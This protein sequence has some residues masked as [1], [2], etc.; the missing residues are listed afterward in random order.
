MSAGSSVGQTAGIAADRR[1]QGSKG[2][3]T[4]PLARPQAPTSWT[5]VDNA[6][7]PIP[8]VERFLVYLVALGRSPRTV[9]AYATTLHLFFQ[10]LELREFDVF[11][12]TLDELANFFTWLR[13]RN[14]PPQGAEPASARSALSDRTLNLRKRLLSTFYRF[15]AVRNP[16]SETLGVLSGLGR[17]WS[18]QIPTSEP[19][20]H[21]VYIHDEVRRPRPKTITDEQVRE[22]LDACPTARDRF[23]LHLL[24]QSGLRIGEAL[25]LHHEDLSP[26]RQLVRVVPRLDNTNGARVK[27]MRPRQVPVPDSVFDSYAHYMT[28]DYREIDS[29]YVFVHLRKHRG[30]PQTVGSVDGVLRKVR[31]QT[32]IRFTPQVARHSYA[33]RL[34]RAGVPLDT[35]ADLLGHADARQTRRTYIHLEVEDHRR[36]LVAAGVLATAQ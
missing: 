9:L 15:Y 25:G 22:L 30:T 8:E 36:V 24:D 1:Q 10:W 4:R 29:K 20:R 2:A 31:A 19:Q 16:Q 23:L 12:P 18:D 32:G 13:T 21:R 27:G 26:Y 6:G 7:T 35:V 34:I 28:N 5:V 33:T 11:E 3:R 14:S 17:R